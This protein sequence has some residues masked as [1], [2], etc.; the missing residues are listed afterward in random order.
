MVYL[1]S[2]LGCLIFLLFLSCKKDAKT[3]SLEVIQKEETVDSFPKLVP[4]NGTFSKTP[5]PF[6]KEKKKELDLYL[7]SIWKDNPRLS[8]GFLVAKNGKIIYEHYQGFSNREDSIL[9]NSNTPI[10]I[11][12]ISKVLTATA[13][14]KL[15]DLGK[16]ELNQKVTT[17]LPLFPYQDITIKMLLN[18]RSGLLNY[19]YFT[20]DEK[21]WD[22]HEIL[23]N[24]DI[25]N[26][27]NQHQFPLQFKPD[28]RF[29]YCNTNYAILALVL[30][31]ITGLN[32]REAMKKMVF[33]PLQ[34]NNTYVFDYKKDT[35][36]AS[37]S[38]TWRNVRYKFN[39][40]DDIYG[41]KNI[42]S[43]PEDLLKFDLATYN[44]NFLNDSLKKQIYKGYSYERK[45]I[46]NYGLGIRLMEWDTGQK[47]LYH[48]GWWHGN[49][50]VYLHLAQDS[51]TIIALGNKYTR[52]IYSAMNLAGYFG[53]YPLGGINEELKHY[54]SIAN[55][56]IPQP[57]LI[58]KDSIKKSKV[59]FRVEDS[60]ST[61]KKLISDSLKKNIIDTLPVLQKLNQDSILRTPASKN[62]QD[63]L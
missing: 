26:L 19:A 9:L 47:L 20:S 16:L 54:D 35:A 49:N 43:T 5:L 2:I 25:L 8:G 46:K 29:T 14:L 40:L 48:N 15:I 31:H 38:Y 58:K 1:K 28:T 61:S 59:S 22:N 18:H 45:G 39:Y 50:T 41:D 7:N 13:I 23:S 4:F 36:T 33:D 56:S 60:I 24:Q 27:M 37:Q 11:A 17:I 53:D 52:R 6:L 62:F 44:P 63:A 10:H 34:M 3:S 42:Y 55:D 51:T 30:E 21:I 32:Y 12:S 57:T